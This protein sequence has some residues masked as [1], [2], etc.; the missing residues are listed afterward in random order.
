MIYP[1]P[2]NTIFFTSKH[3]LFALK[4]VELLNVLLWPL[5]LVFVLFYYISSLFV[6]QG[7]QYY[8]QKAFANWMEQI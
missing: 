8:E 4:K 1:G 2:F 5:S 6:A 3:V 7:A